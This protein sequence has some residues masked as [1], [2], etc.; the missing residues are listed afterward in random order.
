MCSVQGEKVSRGYLRKS[1]K[2]YTKT[3]NNLAATYIWAA[4]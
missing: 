3:S 4:V 1:N 2:D